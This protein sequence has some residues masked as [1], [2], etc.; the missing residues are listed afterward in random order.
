MRPE[1]PDLTLSELEVAVREAVLAFNPR[2]DVS[3]ERMPALTVN[4]LRHTH[5]DY[6][7]DQS[8]EQMARVHAAIAQRLPHLAAECERQMFARRQRDSVFGEYGSTHAGRSREEVAAFR[9]DRNTRCLA[10]MADSA[11]RVGDAVSFRRGRR[12]HTGEIAWLGAT[13]VGVRIV[14]LGASFVE[15][16]YATDLLD[17]TPPATRSLA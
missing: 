17:L 3:P 8:T 10:L 16:V 13:K 7:T 12:V 14:A 6:D 5:T 4:W 9:T 11:Y 15:S 2:A 1:L